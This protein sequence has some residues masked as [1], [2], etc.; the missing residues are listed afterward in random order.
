MLV[1]HQKNTKIPAV[2]LHGSTVSPCSHDGGRFPRPAIPSTTWAVWRSAQAGNARVG[3]TGNPVGVAVTIGD[4]QTDKLEILGTRRWNMLKIMACDYV[5]CIIYH[6]E[7][8]CSSTEQLSGWK[9]LHVVRNLTGCIFVIWDLD[10]WA[11]H[12]PWSSWAVI[13]TSAAPRSFSWGTNCALMDPDGQVSRPLLAKIS[14][15]KKGADARWCEVRVPKRVQ[16][17]AKVCIVLICANDESGW[18]FE[19]DII[20]ISWV[21]T[22][23][24]KSKWTILVHVPRVLVQ[25][26]WT[27]EIWPTPSCLSPWPTKVSGAWQ[28]PSGTLCQ[29]QKTAH[30]GKKPQYMYTCYMPCIPQIASSN[31]QMQQR[32]TR[33]IAPGGIMTKATPCGRS[34]FRPASERTHHWNHSSFQFS[35]R[36]WLLCGNFFWQT[37]WTQWRKVPFD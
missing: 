12:H 28:E 30:C 7:G 9:R 14:V 27:G 21:Q 16:E 33:T 11:M 23:F 6:A 36:S 2:S 20:E 29:C 32:T 25:D 19:R 22:Y 4:W 15:P 26:A 5:W 34:P 10:L 13:A 37:D 8:F 31:F 18:I 3:G 35:T 24:Q 1:L 17:R